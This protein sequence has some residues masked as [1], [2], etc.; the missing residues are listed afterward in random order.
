MIRFDINLTIYPN[1]INQ[2]IKANA[3]KNDFGMDVAFN[4]NDILFWVDWGIG[5]FLFS[6]AYPG[7]LSQEGTEIDEFKTK[8]GDRTGKANM[9]YSA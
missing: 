5:V 6:N 9:E 7:I 4:I 2:S 3:D 8:G 1:S